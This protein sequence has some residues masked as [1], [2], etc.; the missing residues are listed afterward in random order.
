MAHPQNIHTELNPI[1]VS[2]LRLFNRP[3]TEEETKALKKL[4]VNY[5][6]EQLDKEITDVVSKKNLRQQDFDD[7]LNGDD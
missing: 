5:Y 7:V 2:L 1:Q 6:S 4:M 3:M